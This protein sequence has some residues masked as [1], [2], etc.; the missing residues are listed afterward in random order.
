M[1]GGCLCALAPGLRVSIASH[2]CKPQAPLRADQHHHY[3]SRHGETEAQGEG[4]LQSEPVHDLER[5]TFWPSALSDCQLT[6]V[7]SLITSTK[8]ASCVTELAQI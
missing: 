7:I 5:A 6:V 4:E 1:P 3:C 2:S 8:A